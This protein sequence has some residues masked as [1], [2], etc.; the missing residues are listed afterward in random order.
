M[1]KR[2][3]GV[4]YRPTHNLIIRV[5]NAGAL[6]T[7]ANNKTALRADAA[8][9]FWYEPKFK[10]AFSK[11]GF[12]IACAPDYSSGRREM[13]TA[14]VVIYTTMERLCSQPGDKCVYESVRWWWPAGR[15]A[16]GRTI[17]RFICSERTLAKEGFVADAQKVSA[18]AK[19][20]A[21]VL[22]VAHQLP[23]LLEQE[24]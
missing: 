16:D 10:P 20:K 24:K 17:F 5:P 8:R 7:S 2:A 23:Q 4:L 13:V 9:D 22:P 12:A 19:R 15:P 6:Q 3:P 18:L 21:S 14:V 11:R 1:T